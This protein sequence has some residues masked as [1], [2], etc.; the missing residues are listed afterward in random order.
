M[1]QS[2]TLRINHHFLQKAE[3]GFKAEILRMERRGE[4]LQR[5]T[6]N[7]S[8]EWGRAQRE[9]ELSEGESIGSKID[10]GLFKENCVS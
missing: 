3:Q 8:K 6:Q 4:E 10:K 9:L 5:E 2:T 7:A 1:K